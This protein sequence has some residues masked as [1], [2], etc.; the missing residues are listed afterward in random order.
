MR[1]FVSLSVI[2]LPQFQ[3]QFLFGWTSQSSHVTAQKASSFRLQKQHLLATGETA[4]QPCLALSSWQVSSNAN[5]L[6]DE[7][8]RNGAKSSCVKRMHEAR[9][10]DDW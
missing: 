2:L 9:E 4:S 7:Q 1:I 8:R 5:R 3:R 6:W 10:G